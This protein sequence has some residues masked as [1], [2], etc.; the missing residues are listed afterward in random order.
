MA[1][2]GKIPSRINPEPQSRPGPQNLPPYEHEP[3]FETIHIIDYVNIMLKRR[4][5]IVLGVICTV[6]LVGLISKKSKPV[7]TASAKFLPSKNPDMSS[8]MGTLVGGGVIRSFEDNV[9]SEYYMELL[10]SDGFLERIAGKK[11]KSAEMGGDTDLAGYYKVKGAS[12]TEKKA[13]TVDALSKKLGVSVDRITKVVSLSYSTNEPELSAAIVNAIIDEL[14]I[15][16]QDIRG[17]KAKQNRE[18][19]QSQL[20]DNQNL[21]NKAEKEYSDFLRRNVKIA[22]LP[23]L[24]V[25]RDR[26]K[27]AVTVQAEVY[28]TIKKQLELAIIEEQE[29]KSSIEIIK[30]AA[31]PFYKSAPQTMKNVILAG[32][33]SLI[34][35][36]GLAFV[37]E[38]VKKIDPNE[39]RNREFFGYIADIKGDFRK[40]G[41]LVGLGKKRPKF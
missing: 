36:M 10:K 26:L 39:E 33:V 16:N 9:T 14:I 40:V 31:V 29:K 13:R 11:F 23:D 38:F 8:R 22:G 21:L 12:E 30:R 37:L 17:S 1:D 41:R 6:L 24:E 27:R 18:F 3:E 2:E 15:Y 19:I 35:F 32:F 25:E 28:I 7:F 4:W 20:T 5:L 34:L